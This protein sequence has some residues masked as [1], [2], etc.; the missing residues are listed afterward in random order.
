MKDVDRSRPPAV[1][2]AAPDT[3]RRVVLIE[4]DN[5]IAEA[6]VYHLA[7]STCPAWTGSRSAG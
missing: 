3:R 5:D 4:D 1:V 6:I 7:T 2:V